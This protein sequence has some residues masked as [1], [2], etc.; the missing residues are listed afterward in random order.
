MNDKLSSMNPTG[1]FTNRVDNYVK[2]RPSYPP[3]LIQFLQMKAG[4]SSQAVVADIGSGTGILTELLLHNAK[5][6]YAVEPNAAMRAAAEIKLSAVCNYE[7]VEGTAENTTLA[8]KSV[9][10]ITVAQAFHWMEPVAT[11]KEFERILDNRGHVA[12]IWNLRD[13]TA[14][15]MKEYEELKTTFGKDYLDTKRA[16]EETIKVFFKDAPMIVESFPNPQLMDF[17]S[18]KGQLESA[19]YMPLEGEPRYEEMIATLEKLF[20]TYQQ[21]GTIQMDFY[22]KVY[23]NSLPL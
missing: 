2:F 16:D 6:V 10:L 5:K 13:N 7:S 20:N 4:L 3:E 14:P 19:S 23:M 8:N 18:L 22:T 17:T 11:R 15:F 9:H 21:H 1:R 12:L